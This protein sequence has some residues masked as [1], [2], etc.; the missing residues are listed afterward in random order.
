MLKV[1]DVKL[2]Y[3]KNPV[4][5]KK[6][7]SFSWII[8]SD[9]SGVFQTHYRIQVLKSDTFDEILFDS[10]IVDSSESAHVYI[11]GLALESTTKYYYRVKI[12]DN[13]NEE[14]DW[15]EVGYFVTALLDNAE[16]IGD[17]ITIETDDDADNSKGTYLRKEIEI[18]GSI[19]EAYL[20]STAL[21]LYHI[22][23]NGEK[24]GNDELTPGW[25]SYN[26]HLLFQTYDITDRLKEGKN[27]LGAMLGAGWYKGVMGFEWK[28]NLYG[29]KTGLLCQL[30]IK[31]EDG[32]KEIIA[33]DESW[34]GSDSPVIYSEIYDGEIYDSRK[35]KAGWNLI[36]FDDNDWTGVNTIDFNKNILYPQASSKVKEMTKVPVKE[37]IVTPEGDTVID[38]GQNLTGWLKFKL[39]GKE[40]DVVELR[41]FEVL[42]AKGNVYLDNLRNAKQTIKYIC[43]S[44]EIV[45][46]KPYFTFQGF[47]YVHVVSYPGDIKPE[48]FVA[49]AVHS[50]MEETGTFECSNP[51][52]NQLQQNILWSMKGNFLDIP[53]DC[54][55]RNERLGWTGDAQIF[56]RTASYLMNTYTFFRKWLRDL[57][58]DQKDSGGV[59]H[60]V[61]DIFDCY[62]TNDWLLKQGTHS[63]AAWADAAVIIP[64]T[65]YLTF[66]DKKILETQYDSMKAWIEFM[67]KHSNDNIWNYKLQFGDW[68]ALDA[69]EGSY[70]G[71]TPND[72]T[73]TA[74]YA[75]S[76]EL[77]AKIAK[78]LGNSEDYATYSKLYNDIKRSYQETFFT[79]EGELTAQTQ[80][81]HIISLHFNLVPD[82][83][84][85]KIV[86]GLLRLL[87][88]ENGHL[89]TGFVGTPY[90]CHVLSQNGHTKEAY[91]LLLKDDFPSWLYQVKM[92]ATTIWEHWDGIKPD[93]TMW[94]PD[95]NSFNHYAYGAIGEWL[96]RVVAGIEID[97]E[98]PGYKHIII[99]PHVGGGLDYVR[100]SYKSIYGPI[101]VEW[102]VEGSNIRLNVNI[103]HNT[104]ATIALNGE[105]YAEDVGSGQHE[106]VFKTEGR[107]FCLDSRG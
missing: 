101:N 102:R 42:D 82:E 18:K 73:C 22:Y 97:E 107:T 56:A 11:E 20:H 52:I 40:G 48:N 46:Y 67:R 51:D 37:I 57:A 7:P 27:C 41:H 14:S 54:P 62:E 24:V 17:F 1:I 6:L 83:H 35:E 36:E 78:I 75:Y 89:V 9:N 8:E 13:H 63:A 105:K 44:N 28:R 39:E 71:A 87:E 21:G 53:T 106:Y 25:T 91:E 55:Q 65:L 80:T 64:W 33:S 86:N 59:P 85:E 38:F 94:S 88:K 50:D 32:T 3:E 79:K 16:W 77:F 99:N 49:Y 26:K 34:K 61:P 84:R 19:K 92:G 15:S 103:P 23:I 31:Y 95:M 100:A 74:F 76:T 98:K 70:F 2:D 58:A 68:V 5:I 29:K 12:K 47:R 43:S 104:S 72:L 10:G 4:G 81:A 30:V 60:L 90:F 45:T 66:G 69:E 93:G 96:Y